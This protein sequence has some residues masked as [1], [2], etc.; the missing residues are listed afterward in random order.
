VEQIAVIEKEE[1]P[2]IDTTKLVERRKSSFHQYIK[3][4][5]MNEINQVPIK[6]LETL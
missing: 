6:T 1:A 3:N 5:A 4:L 2:K